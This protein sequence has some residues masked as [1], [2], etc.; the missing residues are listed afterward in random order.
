MPHGHSQDVLSQAEIRARLRATVRPGARGGWVATIELGE[1]ASLSRWFEDET[2]ASH[3]PDELAQ[4]LAG[5]R[6]ES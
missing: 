3:Y 1:G 6:D 5:G 2:A 4:W